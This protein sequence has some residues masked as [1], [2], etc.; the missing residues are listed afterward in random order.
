MGSAKFDRKAAYL[1]YYYNNFQSVSSSKKWVVL[2]INSE[3]LW[4]K[5]VSVLMCHQDSGDS[6]TDINDSGN[7][8]TH[9][10]YTNG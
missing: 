2:Y 1:K 9:Y 5:N 8:V 10:V 7:K 6:S 4:E 3:S